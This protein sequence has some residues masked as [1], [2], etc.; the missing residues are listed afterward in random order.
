MGTWEDLGK[1]DA[2]GAPF[3]LLGPMTKA[4]DIRERFLHLPDV[5]HPTGLGKTSIYRKINGETFPRQ[6]P[7]GSNLVVWLESEIM[8][9]MNNQIK[10]SR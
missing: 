3:L 9:W 8:E 1:H 2:M 6:I 5:K 4:T 7:I 10:M